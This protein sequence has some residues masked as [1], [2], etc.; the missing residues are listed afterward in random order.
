LVRT[1]AQTYRRKANDPVDLVLTEVCARL[2]YLYDVGLGYLTLDRPTRSLSGGE[3]R[4]RESHHLLGTRLVNTLFVL[5]EP[6]VGLTRATPSASSVSFNN[7]GMRGIQWS[8]SST[9]R[10]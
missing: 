9:R 6:S 8:W 4:A 2:S 3:N 1:L 7:C 10:A 5:D